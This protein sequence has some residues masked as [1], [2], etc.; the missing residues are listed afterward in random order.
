[1]KHPVKHPKKAIFTMW[2]CDVFC[3]GYKNVSDSDII[4]KK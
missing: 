4:F 3:P 2:D 1:M